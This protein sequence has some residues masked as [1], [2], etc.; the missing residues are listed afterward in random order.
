MQAKRHMGVCGYLVGMQVLRLQPP[1]VPADTLTRDPLRVTK[2]LS[3]TNQPRA[4]HA[5]YHENVILYAAT[6]RLCGPQGIGS[7]IGWYQ[8]DESIA[9]CVLAGR[10]HIS[11]YSCWISGRSM[12]QIPFLNIQYTNEVPICL[13]ML[14][15]QWLLPFLPQCIRCTSHYLN[16]LHPFGTVSHHLQIVLEVIVWCPHKIVAKVLCIQQAFFRCAPEVK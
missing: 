1:P 7:A 6:E 4:F 15:S 3:N 5:T 9:V 12:I 2:P 16:H 14:V 11:F 10:C 8:W 13:S